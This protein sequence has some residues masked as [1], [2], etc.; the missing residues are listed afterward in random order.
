MH[1]LVSFQK[2]NT[3]SMTNIQVKKMQAP[4]IFPLT[5]AKH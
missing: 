1:T 2:L 5:M 4:T 3:K